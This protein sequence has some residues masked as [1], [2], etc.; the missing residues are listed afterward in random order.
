MNF[1]KKFSA[2]ELNYL[3]RILCHGFLLTSYF[4]L[5]FAKAIL[6]NVVTGKKPS[7]RLITKS[8]M[9]LLEPQ[10]QNILHKARSEATC[11]NKL[12]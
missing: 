11:S 3:G 7:I 2:N 12:F 1:A 10:D 6:Y 5:F 4:P 8:F 9:D